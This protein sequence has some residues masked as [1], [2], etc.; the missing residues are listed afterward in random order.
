MKKT[1]I[2]EFQLSA[3]YNIIFAV[4]VI[5]GSNNF[6][7]METKLRPPSPKGYVETVSSLVNKLFKT[8]H[9]V[10]DV[11]FFLNKLQLRG[12]IEKYDTPK[13]GTVLYFV[14]RDGHD[15]VEALEDK[16]DKLK[17]AKVERKE[18]ILKL[19]IGFILPFATIVSSTLIAILK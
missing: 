4:A 17:Q 15:R 14:T 5:D 6:E 12:Y 8:T 9:S 2:R 3:E 11:A 1:N 7:A 13:D 18:R 19:A 16:F 10:V